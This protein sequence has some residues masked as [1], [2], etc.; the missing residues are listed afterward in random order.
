M[1]WFI[2]RKAHNADPSHS[3]ITFSANTSTSILRRHLYSDHIEEWVNACDL[4]KIPITAAPAVEAVRN[5]RDEPAPTPL[6]SE[7]PEYSK[8]AFIDAIV[9][10][11]V[12]D[13]QVCSE[14]YF[15]IK[16]YNQCTV[17]QYH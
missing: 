13:D 3:I 12:G 6:E 9:D 4:L 1:I 14:F 8:E 16:L 17:S 11:V 2:S 15:I 5:F 10:F 7:R